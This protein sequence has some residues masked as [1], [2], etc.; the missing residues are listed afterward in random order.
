MKAKIIAIIIV[1][2]ALF[3]WF[4]VRPAAIRKSCAENAK[5]FKIKNPNRTNEAMNNRYRLCLS[6]NGFKPDDLLRE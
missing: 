4:Q 3:Y 6:E 1:C 5:Q 2:F